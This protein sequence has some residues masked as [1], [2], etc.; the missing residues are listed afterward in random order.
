VIVPWA[1]MPLLDGAPL[2]LAKAVIAA[3]IVA[4]MVYAIMPHYSRRVAGW[5]YR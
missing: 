5:L 1:L 4:L 3:V 2:L